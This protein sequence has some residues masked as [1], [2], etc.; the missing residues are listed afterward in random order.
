LPDEAVGEAIHHGADEAAMEAHHLLEDGGELL[1]LH[2]DTVVMAEE[3]DPGG[4]RLAV[5]A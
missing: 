3:W 2:R 1:L 5:L 4:A